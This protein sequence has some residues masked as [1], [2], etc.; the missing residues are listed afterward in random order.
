V[1]HYHDYFHDFSFYAE[2]VVDVIG[3]RGPGGALDA[4]ISELE[5]NE[6]AAARASGRFYDE[7]EFR[8]LWE[9]TG[10]MWVVV[11]KRNFEELKGGAG[12]HY[13]LLGESRDHYLISNR[14]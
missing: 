14:P 6:D 3:S 7:A 9:G 5:L 13:Y 11:R 10:R 1:A 2:R 12:F 4:N 8:R